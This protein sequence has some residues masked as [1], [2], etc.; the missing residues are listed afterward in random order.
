MPK[1]ASRTCCA[2]T[3]VRIEPPPAKVHSK[4]SESTIHGPKRRLGGWKKGMRTR[5][6]GRSNRMSV[7]CRCDEGVKSRHRRL[8]DRMSVCLCVCVYR[9]VSLSL[10]LCSLSARGGQTARHRSSVSVSL[11][12]RECVCVSLHLFCLP[13]SVCVTSRAEH[14]AFT[15][16]PR[17]REAWG[18]HRL[19]IQL[20]GLQQQLLGTARGA[21]ATSA[22]ATTIEIMSVQTEECSPLL[23]EWARHRVV[24]MVLV[25]HAWLAGPSAMRWPDCARPATGQA[26]NS[27]SPPKSPCDHMSSGATRMMKH[28]NR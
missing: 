24:C 8:L 6:R 5:A 17:R 12:L 23:K 19:A 16:A 20:E 11:C 18:T 3:R 14:V 28:D 21:R 25:R 1:P 10:C 22:R 27:P 9:C 13:A 2:A 4:R 15:S 26:M 7:C